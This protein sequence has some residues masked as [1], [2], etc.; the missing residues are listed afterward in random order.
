MITPIITLLIIL[1]RDVARVM[2]WRGRSLCSVCDTTEREGLSCAHDSLSI[3]TP[4]R[5]R[6]QHLWHGRLAR[7]PAR[8]D[9]D[10][11]APAASMPLTRPASAG[12]PL[13][14]ERQ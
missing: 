14:T 10:G 6:G 7:D 3:A 8:R 13:T 9:Q 4:E 12:H 1:G 2:G 11:H 5:C